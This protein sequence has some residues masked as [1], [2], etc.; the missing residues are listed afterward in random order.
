MANEKGANTPRNQGIA[1]K[2]AG[3]A[4]L[5]AKDIAAQKKQKEL[6]KVNEK[7]ASEANDLVAK[8]AK[9]EAQAA[10]VSAPAAAAQ[11]EPENAT[12]AALQAQ[13]LILS[14]Q[15]VAHQSAQ[16]VGK[17]HYKPVPSGDFQEVGVTFSCRQ[18]YFVIGSYLDAKGMEIMPPYKLF[19]FQY[20]ASDIRKDGMESKV[21]NS[22]TFT[23][24]LKAE[25]KF[26][27]DHPL[28]GIKFFENMNDTMNADAIY[29][30]FR[31]KAATQVGGMTDEAVLKACHDGG[32]KNVDRKGLPEL[33]RILGGI[34]GEQ[35][36]KEAKE[37]QDDQA[38]RRLLMG[39][40]A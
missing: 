30:E 21:V 15:M 28:H 3:T 5:S 9:L 2:P 26:L 40:T 24:H 37:L 8:I 32:I 36:I 35:Y 6:E 39:A 19:K 11:P 18:V 34:L 29:S 1:A 31:V 17:P 7:L 27:R 20:A 23:T 33:R 13:V 4:T 12:I 16:G 22:C 25:M 38:R 14:N 10:E